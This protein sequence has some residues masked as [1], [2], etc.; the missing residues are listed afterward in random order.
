[1]KWL[2][3]IKERRAHALAS[4]AQQHQNIKIGHQDVERINSN[5][6]INFS[7]HRAHGGY[8]IEVTVYNRTTDRHNRSLHII[9]DDK[10]LGQEIGKI[11][12]YEGLRA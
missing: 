2:R 12:T 11:I 1:M 5:Q 3:N 9:T 4:A 6:G 10:D 7:V 8:V